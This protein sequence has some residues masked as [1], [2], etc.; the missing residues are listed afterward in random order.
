MIENVEKAVE[1]DHFENLADTRCHSAEQ[2]VA[3]A[4]LGLPP[5]MQH[6]PQSAAGEVG[7][8]TQIEYDLN[9]PTTQLI[10][11]RRFQRRNSHRIQPAFR[12]NVIHLA[13]RYVDDF[14][15]DFHS[16]EFFRRLVIISVLPSPGV[17]LKVTSSI[18]LRMK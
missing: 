3:P 10:L 16:C 13:A 6:G 15:N 18:S 7:H 1:P 4:R 17:K 8:S 2:H 12:S 11:Q 9:V 5:G 14:L